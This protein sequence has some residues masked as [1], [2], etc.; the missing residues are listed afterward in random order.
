M[1]KRGGICGFSQLKEELAGL[2]KEQENLVEGIAKHGFL[3]AL[4]ARLA[5]VDS[6][7]AQIQRLRDAGVE[8]KVPE[9]T[10]EEIREFVQR[11]SQEFANIL[12]GDAAIAREQLR[13]RITKVVLTPKQTPHGPVFEVTGD[14]SLFRGSGDMMLTNSLER[15]AEHYTSFSISRTGLHLNP[16]TPV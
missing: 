3:H 2:K 11:K 7:I 9:F 4:S 14:V 1:S 6:R 5:T 13:K 16:G 15:I 12:A 10:T 8:P